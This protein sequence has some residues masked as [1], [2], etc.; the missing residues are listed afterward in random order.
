MRY[1]LFMVLVILLI[2][3]ILMLHHLGVAFFYGELEGETFQATILSGPESKQYVNS[4]IGKID[5]KKYILYLRN[6]TNY[7][8]RRYS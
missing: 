1:R 7:S 5:G 2:M 3:I 4:Y 6:G 8:I